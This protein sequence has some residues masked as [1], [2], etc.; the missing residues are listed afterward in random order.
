MD[1]PGLPEVGAE[2]LRVERMLFAADDYR[3]PP[4]GLV[5]I[6]LIRGG[7]SS[8]EID[9]GAGPHWVFTRPG[10]ILLSLPESETRFKITEQRELTMISIGSAYAASLLARADGAIGDLSTI[11]RRP[12]RDP[13]VAA[14]C[15]RLSDN[16]SDNPVVQEWTLGL[17]LAALLQ[18]ARGVRDSFAK[19]V[20]TTRRLAAVVSAIDAT[21]DK[22]VSVDHL[23]QVAGMPRRAFSAAFREATGLPVHQYVLRRRVERAADMLVSTALPIAEVAQR[24][25]F[26][27]QAHMTRVMSRLLGRTPG[28][29]RGK[30]SA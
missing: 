21:R 20:F 27:H 2:A 19:V 29:V 4:S 22:A 24:V 3:H 30:A 8:A 1:G 25:G 10:D 28:Q 6:R 12:M 23:A 5:Q 16:G 7:S 17:L 11:A 18:K 15:R 26:A 13:L 14:L 9:L